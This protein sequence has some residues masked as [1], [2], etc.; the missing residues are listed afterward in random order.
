MTG[1]DKRW[2]AAGAALA[3]GSCT[4][5]RLD[6]DGSPLTLLWFLLAIAG[7]VLMLNGKRVATAWRAERSGHCHTAE[8]IPAARVCHRRQGSDGFGL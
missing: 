4:A 5:T 1:R 2:R 6:P 8:A 7:L 3:I